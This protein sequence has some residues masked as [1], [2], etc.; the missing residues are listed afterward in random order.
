MPSHIAHWPQKAYTS[1][2]L[3]KLEGQ[4]MNFQ[5]DLIKDKVE[6]LKRLHCRS[7]KRKSIHKLKT[8]KPS[9]S[10]WNLFH[11]KLLWQKEEYCTARWF[12]S[13]L[14]PKTKAAGFNPAAFVYFSFS[15]FVGFQPFSS[16]HVIVT[17]YLFPVALS[18]ILPLASWGLPLFPSQS[19]VMLSVETPVAYEMAFS[20]SAQSCELES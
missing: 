4:D 7:L 18:K 14:K 11:T 17:W 20:I 3:W 8:I 6:F 2:D 12:I 15:T 1:Y 19:T 13:Q 5:L 10:G 9:C 16:T